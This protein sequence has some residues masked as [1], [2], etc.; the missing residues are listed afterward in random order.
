M[1]GFDFAKAPRFEWTKGLE[2]RYQKIQAQRRGEQKTRAEIKRSETVIV[3]K[4]PRTWMLKDGR[5]FEALFVMEANGFA[6][7]RTNDKR[8]MPV[9]L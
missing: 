2:E 7:L 5:S 8:L 1:R 6:I 3:T 4:R 9:K